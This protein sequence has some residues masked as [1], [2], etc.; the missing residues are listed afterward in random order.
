MKTLD[1]KE[2]QVKE[3]L[4]K[5]V[6]SVR[7]KFKTL[8]MSKSGE[9][10]ENIEKFKPITG[11][12]D[13]L[14]GVPETSAKN[15]AIEAKKRSQDQQLLVKSPAK[16]RSKNELA[17][18]FRQKP[19]PPFRI[20]SQQI[21]AKYRSMKRRKQYYDKMRDMVAK[22]PSN[23]QKLIQ[24]RNDYESSAAN[25]EEEGDKKKSRSSSQSTESSESSEGAN[26]AG[27]STQ[28]IDESAILISSG[29]SQ[30]PKVLN[31]S[32][33]IQV[34][35]P[36]KSV[37]G[38]K[39]MSRQRRKRLET[40]EREF[41]GATVSKKK[42]GKKKGGALMPMDSMRYSDSANIS[43]S[44]WNDPNELVDRLRLLIASKTAGHSGHTNEIMSIIEELR[45]AGIIV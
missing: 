30:S 35:T 44:Y 22:I 13:A 38:R 11:K 9:E 39:K 34:P 21:L 25:S 16:K 7:N 14:F 29:E 27:T 41:T 2:K 45:E 12:L 33:N 5:A 6:N 18:K 20:H 17:D 15:N 1:E 43:Y 28:G 32:K 3:S 36:F 4:V 24:K 23:I 10:L 26:P 42:Q 37:S 31:V 40:E 19:I 8:H